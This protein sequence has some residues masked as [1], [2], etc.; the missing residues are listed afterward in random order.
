MKL[1]LSI[2]LSDKERL[3]GILFALQSSLAF[4]ANLTVRLKPFTMESYST[5]RAENI[6][7]AILTIVSL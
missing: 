6:K 1:T 2:T 4:R 5:S 7:K 3:L